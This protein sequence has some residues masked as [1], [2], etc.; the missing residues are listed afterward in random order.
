MSGLGWL[1]FVV[2]QW[3][4]VRLARQTE[5]GVT[6]GWVLLVPVIPLTGWLSDYRPKRRLVLRLT[7]RP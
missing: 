4:F 5:N 1:N 3:L 2:A 6:V 7:K